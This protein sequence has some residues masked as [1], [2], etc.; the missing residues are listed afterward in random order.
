[1]QV[2][3][4]HPARLLASLLALCGLLIPA[5]ISQAHSTEIPASAIKI[6]PMVKEESLSTYVPSEA[7][8]GAGLAVNLIYTQ[9]P[10]YKDGA[11]VLVLVPGGNRNQGLDFSM[12]AAQQGFVEIRFAFPGGGKPGFMSSGIYDNRGIKCQEALRDVLRFAAGEIDDN[13]GKKISE[14]LPFRTSS[15]SIGAVGWSNGG[16]LLLVT[17]AKYLD[18]LPFLSWM[19]F[20]ESPVGAMFQTGA[21]GSSQD[22][23]INK[24]YRQG[25]AATG[26]VVV[27]F[28]KLRYQPGATKSPGSHK[29]LDEPEIPGLVFFDE[30][31]NGV[32][33][34]SS[35]FAV[36]YTTDIGIEKQIYPPQVVKALSN[37]PEFQVEKKPES[38]GEKSAGG[39]KPAASKFRLPVANY[40][41]SQ[42]FF[43]ERDGSLYVKQIL[44]QRPDLAITIFA[45]QLDHFQRQ[46][47]HPHI[48]LLYNAMLESKP[49]FLR[50]NPSSVYVGHVGHM[51]SSTFVENR[52]NSSIEADKIDQYLEPEGL[53]PDYAY[54][55]AAAC[56]LADRVET[57]KWNK[58]LQA[59]LNTFTNGAKTEEEEL[60]AQKAKQKAGANGTPSGGEKTKPA[61]S[62]GSKT[63]PAASGETSGTKSPKPGRGKSD[64]TA[65]PEVSAPQD[66]PFKN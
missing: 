4:A 16:N 36:P 48:A 23:F 64:K 8:P 35:E 42:A 52:P 19:A 21:L 31:G 38:K 30:N 50:L 17:L 41:E 43:R 11:P 14:L 18:S 40:E 27:D 60:E 55:E 51:K 39:D 34:E 28:R 22:M 46:N 25:T 2:S 63:G 12:H 32:W 45:S 10:R 49:K 3:R 58:V 37:L 66:W 44:R 65:K 33:E 6:P 61:A 7:A 54:M 13:Q 9:N 57:G 53:L 26:Q 29:K 20:Y 15:K 56:E 24:H 47:D 1:M 5:S 59:P 62:V